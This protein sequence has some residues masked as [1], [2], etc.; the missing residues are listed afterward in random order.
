M[1]IVYN[2]LQIECLMAIQ[3]LGKANVMIFLPFLPPNFLM[4]RDD[5]VRRIE[6]KLLG[7]TVVNPESYSELIYNF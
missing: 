4:T 7:N 5:R 1:K 3:V 6:P 2:H